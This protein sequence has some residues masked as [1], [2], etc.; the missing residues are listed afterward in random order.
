MLDHLNNQHASIRFELEFTDDE[1]FL[2]I[3]DI[4]LKIKEDGT[5]QRKV[6]TKAVNKGI[7]LHSQSHH[8][9]STKVAVMRN[10]FH[11]AEVNSTSEFQ[12]DARAVIN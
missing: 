8:P 2:L 4:K 9:S 11:R 7:I 5:T 3:L 1:G 10:E 12:K 6:H